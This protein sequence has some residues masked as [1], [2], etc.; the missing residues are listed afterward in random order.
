M[1]IHN[2][3]CQ[4]EQTLEGGATAKG[5]QGWGGRH[6][7]H[8][9][10]PMRHNHANM[11]T[12]FYYSILLYQYLNV[13]EAHLAKVLPTVLNKRDHCTALWAV[14]HPSMTPTGFLVGWVA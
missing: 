12:R 5:L 4:T 2:K 9:V 3:K 1:K 7:Y 14:Q 6:E 13:F 10:M 8:H 11:H